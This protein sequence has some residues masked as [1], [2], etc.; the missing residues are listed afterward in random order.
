MTDS[1]PSDS[2]YLREI[3]AERSKR[4]DEQRAM[5][6]DPFPPRTGRTHTLAEASEFFVRKRGSR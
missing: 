3:I 4:A 2:Q 5:G 6:L 1:T